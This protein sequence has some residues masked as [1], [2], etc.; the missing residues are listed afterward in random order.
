MP[1]LDD[2]GRPLY[3]HPP[4]LDET[5][6]VAFL[7]TQPDIVAAY[8]FGSLAQGR[9]AAHS[10]I[11]IAVL[12]TG[13][14]D[15]QLC[16]DR[17]LQLMGDLRVFADGELGIVV[18]NSASLTTQYQVLRSGRR[19]CESDRG[20]RVEFEVRVGKYYADLQESWAYLAQELKPEG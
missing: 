1:A 7:A 4:A 18:L 15:P 11:D 10:D 3:D 14:P 12:L 5:G 17:Q 16:T 19:L 2:Y 8:L 20:T 9:A 13:D 6:L